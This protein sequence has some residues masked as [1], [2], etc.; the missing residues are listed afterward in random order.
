[1]NTKLNIESII[2]GS[3]EKVKLAESVQESLNKL[4]SKTDIV[5][6]QIFLELHTAYDDFQVFSHKR[7][8]E[9]HNR[10]VCQRL[11]E[12]CF[13]DKVP[14]NEVFF[15]TINGWR[16]G[17]PYMETAILE[18]QASEIIRASFVK[19]N[20]PV[21][22]ISSIAASIDILIIDAETLR[23]YVESGEDVFYWKY[24]S[25]QV[26]SIDAIGSGAE[27]DVY[28]TEFTLEE[29]TTNDTEVKVSPGLVS[30]I[31][32]K[33]IIVIPNMRGQ[34]C[35]A[36]NT[37][38]DPLDFPVNIRMQIATG[39]YIYDVTLSG[40]GAAPQ[41]IPTY[42]R[43]TNLLSGT[44]NTINGVNI[45]E[46]KNMELVSSISLNGKTYTPSKG[47]VDLGEINVEEV[48]FANDL[49]GVAEA[50]PEMFTYRPSAGDKSV[51]DE[52]AVIRRIKGNTSVWSQ[53]AKNNKEMAEYRS[54]LFSYDETTKIFTLTIDNRQDN[55][56][57]NIPCSS[58]VRS[59]TGHKY[60]LIHSG[61]NSLGN[62]PA[63]G[64]GGYY[65]SF[66]TYAFVTAKS[67]AY[68]YLFPFGA[69]TT[70]VPAG[71]TFTIDELQCYDLTAIFGVGNE[72]TTLEEFRALY[73]KKDYPYSAPVVRSMRVTGIETVG[74][75]QWDEEWEN[76]R[77][78]TNT[79]VNIESTN[80]RCKNLI[81]VL[82]NTVYALY[83]G[84]SRSGIYAMFYDNNGNILTPIINGEDSWTIG[85]CLRIS[86]AIRYNTFIT[87]EGASWMKFYAD[88]AYGSTY[89]NDVC[90]SLF[91]SGIRRG[92]YKPYEK[93]T[94]L[95]PEIVKYFPEGMHGIGDVCD[96]IIDGLA[97]QRIGEVDLGDLDWSI[98]TTNENNKYSWG[99]SLSTPSIGTSEIAN[100]ICVKYNTVSANEVYLLKD[101]TI[102]VLS[103]VTGIS[104]NIYD[105]NYTAATDKDSFVASLQGVKLYYELAEPIYTPID[106]PLQLTYKVDDFGTEKMLSDAPS[107]PFKADIVYQFNA[108]GRIR[109]N[110]RNIEKLENNKQDKLTSGA[111]IKFING[112][113]VLG[114]GNLVIDGNNIFVA[115]DL[116]KQ[117]QLLNTTIKQYGELIESK[118]VKSETGIPA[119]DLSEEVQTS[120]GKADNSVRLTTGGGDINPGYNGDK[121]FYIQKVDGV[122]TL[123]IEMIS[124]SDVKSGKYTGNNGNSPFVGAD[125]VYDL[126]SELVDRKE[127]KFTYILEFS[128][129]ELILN[130]KCTCDNAGLV[131]AINNRNLILVKDEFVNGVPVIKATF[132]ST[133]KI[134]TFSY[135]GDSNNFYKFSYKYDP[136][137]NINNNTLPIDSMSVGIN[138][139]M[140][141][142]NLVNELKPYVLSFSLE[143]LNTI[144]TSQIEIN[145]TELYDVIR[146]HQPI[147]IRNSTAGYGGILVSGWIE[148]LDDGERAHINL[149]IPTATGFWKINGL[150][151]DNTVPD[152]QTYTITSSNVTKYSLPNLSSGSANLIAKANLKSING[153]SIYKEHTVS[154]NIYTYYPLYNIFKPSMVISPNIFYK[155]GTPESPLSGTIDIKLGAEISSGVV[156]EYIFEIYT[157]TE[158]VPT[159]SLSLSD[160][161]SDIKWV[162]GNAPVLE[163]NKIY[164]ISIINK[165]GTVLSWDNV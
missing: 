35:I 96:E 153:N 98:R 159:L 27:S 144:A 100:I 54:A 138:K 141:S 56:A 23:S 43:V 132:D 148:N 93:N 119:T 19:G 99:S 133:T 131:N 123:K 41:T 32:N 10:E 20:N 114:E 164:Q 109:D 13:T 124:N 92:E 59:I 16:D 21:Q 52:S 72:P 64:I 74:F 90:I 112:E 113:S 104:V 48:K 30:A 78:D 67:V 6:S 149:N 134:I 5:A 161:T 33:K 39:V 8:Y 136:D 147:I 71:S 11:I 118:Y 24:I 68:F 2:D 63:Y 61:T 88:T 97:I 84:N 87:P 15:V 31:Y 115:N 143:N 55:S 160:G 130:N 106:E 14:N 91:H 139:E 146:N 122:Q 69:S 101:K 162:S 50:T 40:K 111:N 81:K 25:M 126:Y 150:I 37:F 158:V 22:N 1:M 95:L 128:L 110:S 12:N 7:G 79:G 94:L 152:V 82:P 62:T 53:I 157:S 163:E 57:L 49:T 77:F 137:N 18:S 154:G 107:S 9:E 125:I 102:A 36:T 86:S 4:E 103:N 66:N 70:T 155:F 151:F 28:V 65:S 60:L 42:V 34:N 127:E 120:L 26:P 116:D 108:E 129:G 3:I 51:R 44:L 145:V 58:D 80:I 76:G 17:V 46:G 105:S 165:L 75:N 89:T 85:N 83:V 142:T 38:S 73:P 29:I 140:L 135:F 47:A 117:S 156:N 45:T 121:Q